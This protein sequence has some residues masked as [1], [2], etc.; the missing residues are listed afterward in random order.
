MSDSD[1]PF[2]CDGCGAAVALEDA[3][4]TKT[5]GGLDPAKWQ[6]LCCPDC[7]SRLRTVYVGD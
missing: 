7:G 3:R 5:M 4:R 2:D 6:T 1:G